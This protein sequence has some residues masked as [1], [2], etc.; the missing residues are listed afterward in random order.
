[1][2]FSGSRSRSR[3]EAP[4]SLPEQGV[5]PSEAPFLLSDFDGEGYVAG[6]Q[7]V[8]MRIANQAVERRMAAAD[9]RNYDLQENSGEDDAS[10]ALD[11][12]VDKR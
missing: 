3:N 9:L 10:R 7:E 2:L 4:S 11:D 6:D 5:F 12:F 1:M 8:L